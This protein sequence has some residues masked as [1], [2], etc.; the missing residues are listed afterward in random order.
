VVAAGFAYDEDH[1]VGA[2]LLAMASGQSTWMLKLMAS[3]PASSH[4]RS[5][6]A[7]GFAYDEDHAVGASLLAIASGQSTWMLKLMASSPAS[8]HRFCAN[9]VGAV[10]CNEAAIF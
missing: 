2:S 1:A 8:S 3:S 7:A 10:E 4:R 5:V 6:L 9:P